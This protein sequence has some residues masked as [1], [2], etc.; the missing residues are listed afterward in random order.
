MIPLDLYTPWPILA[1]LAGAAWL[2]LGVM[3]WMD[4]RR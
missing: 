1:L 4:R 2:V 3:V